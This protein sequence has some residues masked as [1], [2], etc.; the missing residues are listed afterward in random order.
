MS[1][2]KSEM[3]RRASRLNTDTCASV[4]ETAAVAVAA[5]IPVGGNIGTLAQ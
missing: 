2:T 5:S 1:T 4:F 3:R